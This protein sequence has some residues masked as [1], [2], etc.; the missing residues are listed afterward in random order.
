MAGFKIGNAKEGK[1]HIVPEEAFHIKFYDSLECV[2]VVKVIWK[3]GK[4]GKPIT[5]VKMAWLEKN[6]SFLEK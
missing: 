2:T 6:I 5:K 3:P 4:V 1:T